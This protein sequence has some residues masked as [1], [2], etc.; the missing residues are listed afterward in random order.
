MKIVDVNVLLY[1]VNQ[2]SPHH[3]VAK[4]W[5]EHALSGSERIALPWPVLVAFLRLVTNGRI[6]PRPMAVEDAVALVDAWLER[7]QVVTLTPTDEHWSHLRPLVA[8]AGAAGNLTSDAHL[9]ALSLEHSAELC[10]FDAD[11]GRFP[12]VR[13]VSPAAL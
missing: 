8:S 11:F 3:A 10:S 6:F 12:G 7:P 13:W 4:A 9:A 5:L 1:A 2:D